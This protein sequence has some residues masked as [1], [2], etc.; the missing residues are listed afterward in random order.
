[1][2][3]DAR[4][5]SRT[6]P[7][8]TPGRITWDIIADGLA[9]VLALVWFAGLAPQ[10]LGAR[11]STDE[12]FHAFMSQWIAA[13]G[14]LPRTIPELYSGFSYY[15]PPLYHILGAAAVIVGGAAGF[16]LL[17]LAITA[18]LLFA[19]A[20]LCR[21]LGSAAAGRWAVC[22]CVANA[23]LG[24]HAVR[25]YVEQLTTLLVVTAL[26]M[27]LVVR[28]SQHARSAV[29]LGVVIGLALVAKHSSIA[30]V[31]IT[32]GL[33]GFYA[34]RGERA[35]GRHFAYAAVTGVAIALP[36]F[37]R[38]QLFY[39]SPIYPALAP[40]LH[41]LL[42]ALNKATF[43]PSPGSFY[44]QMGLYIGAGI[45][46]LTLGALSIAI[47]R[48]RA[49]LA[50]GLIAVCLTL[51]A[52]APLQPLLDSRHLLPVIVALAVLGALVVAEAL[53]AR[54]SLM[55][56]C[57]IAML[58]VAA[59]FVATLQN[60]R[61]YLDAPAELDPV[62]QAVR[63]HV[64]ERAT[65]LSLYTYDTLFYTGRAATWPIPWGQAS[66]PVEMFLTADCD[67]ALTALR[68]HRIQYALVPNVAQGEAFNGANYPRAFVECMAQLSR[69]GR[70]L[71]RW[72]SNTTTLIEVPER[73]DA[74]W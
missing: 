23:W 37:V 74:P 68:Y 42:Y 15:Y 29:V 51:I 11:L 73:A 7:I 40:D 10:A 13:H 30:L 69:S 70:I 56:A 1:M 48:R 32:L 47:M 34:L 5:R 61:V 63:E 55:V 24:V 46:V 58:V 22:L 41:P 38:N 44:R 39:G 72:T 62:M 4:E 53:S 71:V 50:I 65:V 43:T 25:M 19:I 6:S 2:R 59:Y 52:M 3:H 28:R 18:V 21:R 33:A 17:N 26:L 20:I 67:S 64:P 16:K 35:V 31:A 12:C 8:R 57:D 9:L 36:M 14:A 27:M 49:T 54:R 60:Y 66:H 45:G